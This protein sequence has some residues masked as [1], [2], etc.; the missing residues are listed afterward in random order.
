MPWKRIWR[1]TPVFLPGKSHGQ[2]SLGGCSPQNHGRVGY[3][4][5]TKQQQHGVYYYHLLSQYLFF[6][7]F[8]ALLHCEACGILVPW[9]E[10]DP[11]PSV[12]KVWSPNHWTAGEFPSKLS[13]KGKII[14][15]DYYRYLRHLLES[16]ASPYMIYNLSASRRNWKGLWQHS[17]L[18]QWA[19]RNKKK[20]EINIR[21]G[22]KYTP[23]QSPATVT[24]CL[25]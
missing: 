10:I 16:F 8:S 9:P 6:F 7:F 17:A 4:L 19:F 18:D 22:R 25:I 2:R 5:V 24:E 3:D 21:E 15:F 23:N 11:K 12:M 13:W 20:Q 14:I 1:S